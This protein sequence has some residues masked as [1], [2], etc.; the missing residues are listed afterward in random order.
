MKALHIAALAL[1]ILLRDALPVLRANFRNGLAQLSVFDRI[2]LGASAG[3]HLLDHDV[4][5][6]QR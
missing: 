5:W 2:P 3:V 1:Q 6:V 4:V